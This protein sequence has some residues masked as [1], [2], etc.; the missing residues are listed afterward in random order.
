MENKYRLTKETVSY[1]GHTLHRIEALKDF[2]NVNEGDFGGWVEKEANLSQEGDCWISGGA[3]VY[4]NAQVRD[5]A[6]VYGDAQVC[7]DAQ[8]RDDAQVYS[9][10]QVCGDA[11]VFG[12]ALVY[13]YARVYGNAWVCDDAQVYGSALVCGDTNVYGN[14]RVCG[15]AV[16]ESKSEICG[17]AVVE[18]MG[19]Y[20]LFQNTWS[21][22]RWF[23]YTKSNG[24]WKVGCFYGT[25]EELV[26]KAY[27]DSEEKGRMYEATVN[28][29]ESI[30]RLKNNP[31]ETNNK[32]IAR[33]TLPSDK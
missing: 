4:D 11:R 32:Q 12:N 15:T 3:K 30:E 20:M 16:V 13:D 23:T 24:K 5:D 6:Q 17:D 29:L 33:T 19:D 18:K 21:S 26:R 27:A 22:G 10:A 31:N 14:V 2:G 8:V 1:R 7:G 25:G 28:Y 9:D